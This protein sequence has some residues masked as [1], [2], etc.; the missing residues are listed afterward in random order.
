MKH[1][2]GGGTEE[3]LAYQMQPH[4]REALEFKWRFFEDQVRQGNLEMNPYTSY[5]Q[6]VGIP[7]E[8]LM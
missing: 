3:Y 8:K 1:Y 4:E 5:L 7:T 6:A 2:T